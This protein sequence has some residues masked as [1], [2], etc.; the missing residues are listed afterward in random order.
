MLMHTEAVSF[1]KISREIRNE[2]RCGYV[3]CTCQIVSDRLMPIL[4]NFGSQ[5]FLRKFRNF[6][7]TGN[8][9][10]VV[11]IIAY[12]VGFACVN[13]LEAALFFTNISGNKQLG[14]SFTGNSPV[15]VEIIAYKVG[16]ACVNTLEAA[17]FF[18]NI[19]GNKQLGAPISVHKVFLENFEIL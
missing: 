7:F 9:P 1:F 13:T 12:K 16:F 11:E 3:H 5:R 18:T 8:S 19:S 14:A 2:E 4:A 15:V 6:S 17:L 10:V